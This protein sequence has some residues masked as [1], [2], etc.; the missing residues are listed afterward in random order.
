MPA[1]ILNQGAIVQCD[2]Q[3]KAEPNTLAAKVLIINKPVVVMGTG[4]HYSFAACPNPPPNASNGPCMTAIFSG[5]ATKVFAGNLP[6]LV[7]TSM[8]QCAPTAVTAKATTVT[9]KVVMAT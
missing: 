2:H 5:P 7:M 6:V 1:F 4:P 9:D 3:G 8:G